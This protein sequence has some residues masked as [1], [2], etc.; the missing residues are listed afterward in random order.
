[1]LSQTSEYALQATLYIA[2]HESAGPVKL[3]RVAEALRLPRN[4]LSKTLHL[5]ARAGVLASERGPAGGFRLGYRPESLTL[6]TIVEP[7][8][9][10]RL[11]RRCVMG[12]GICSDATACAAHARWKTIAE[13]MRAFFNETT[14]ADL[15]DGEKV[16]EVVI[17]TQGAA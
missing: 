12:Q 15:L 10:T 9:P 14:V 13:P 8:D 6:G 3:E 5:L 2:R 17:T 7:F 11:A 16:V 4:Y 1:M